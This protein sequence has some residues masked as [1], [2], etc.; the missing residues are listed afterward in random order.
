MNTPTKT[1]P[2]RRLVVL[3]LVGLLVVA[4]VVVFWF[5]PLG[6][7][8]AMEGT[9]PPRTEVEQKEDAGVTL[10]PAPDFFKDLDKNHDRRLTLEALRG[11]PFFGPHDV[12]AVN[13]AAIDRPDKHGKRDGRIDPK[14]YAAYVKKWWNRIRVP[15][16]VQK[17]LGILGPKGQAV[18]AVK[19]PTETRPLIMPGSTDLDPTRLGRVRARFQAEVVKLGTVP[20]TQVER[21][22]AAVPERELRP[23]D[24]VRGPRKVGDKEE[25]G[26]LL[27]VVWSIDVGS[28]KSELVDALVQLKLDEGR[29]Q[30][31][32]KLWQSG[33]LPRDTL[34]QTRRDVASDR[35]AVERAVR[36]LRTWRIPQAEIDDVYDEAT[37]ILERGGIHNRK[38]EEEWARS[39]IRSPRDGTI[40][41]RN[42]VQ[43]EYIADTTTNLFVIADVDRLLVRAST[44]EDDLPVLLSLPRAEQVW[45]VHAV[46]LPAKQRPTPIDEISQII[47][48]NQHTAVVKGYIDNPDG[49]L[50]AGQ[51]VTARVELPPPKGVVEVPVSALVDDH[52]FVQDDPA[53][54]NRFTLRRVLVTHRFDK[55]VYVKSTLTPDEARLTPDERARDLL[56]RQPLA[57]GERVLTAGVLELKARLAELKSTER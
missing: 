52:L 7:R 53:R 24:R 31:R 10:V 51:Y 50:R 36:I 37:K 54:P 28:K 18:V 3:G 43:S 33:G 27:A 13:F 5:D 34:E 22:S 2:L 25:P 48:Q 29:L 40:V 55:T 8:A 30:E 45:T 39:E 35:N 57:K 38:K 6:L 21:I 14:E 1:S 47:D 56:P 46:G 11:L 16:D 12:V 17:S 23:G 42:V 44:P 49:R 19:P 15:T 20:D 26:T 41:E 32:L 4:G 9:A